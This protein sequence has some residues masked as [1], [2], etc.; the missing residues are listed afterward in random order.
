MT[1]VTT[2]VEYELPAGTDREEATRMFAA[3]VPRYRATAGLLRKNVLYREGIGGGVYLWASMTA[4]EAAFSDEWRTYMTEKY[5]SAPRLVFYE[6][7]I[8]IEN[9]YAQSADQD[10]A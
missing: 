6:T 4:A 3:S 5:G 2:V 9:Q 10:A 1:M 8:V 7:P